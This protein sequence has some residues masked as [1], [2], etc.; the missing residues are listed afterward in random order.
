MESSSSFEKASLS[1]RSEREVVEYWQSIVTKEPISEDLKALV[2]ADL[3]KAWHYNR[4]V[5]FR[6][7][8]RI[9]WV[10]L[11]SY[12][13]LLEDRIGQ[14]APAQLKQLCNKPTAFYFL[15]SAQQTDSAGERTLVP[16]IIFAIICGEWFRTGN[17]EPSIEFGHF[18]ANPIRITSTGPSTIRGVIDAHLSLC[19]QASGLMNQANDDVDHIIEKPPLNLQHYS[20]LP[21]YHAIVVLIDQFDRSEKRSVREPDGFISLR[22]LAQ[23]QTVLLARTGAEEGLSAPISFDSLRSHSLPLQR[24]DAM[25]PNVDVVRVSIAVAVKFIASLEAREELAFSK[26][27]NE[28]FLDNRLNPSTPKG[29]EGNRQVC[30][31]PEAWADAH[32]VSAEKHGYDNDFET[33]W[34]IRRVQASLVGEDFYELEHVPFGNSWKY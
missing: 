13:I 29:F 34:S 14:L 32:I 33:R 21:L 31:N 20:L 16:R 30:C 5:I 23:T 26:S 8:M 12:L 1:K 22:K 9:C 28:F 17:I 7:D 10:T 11:D 2:R 15:Q 24:C 27:K 4:N 18:F 3:E 19:A 25:M 6:Q